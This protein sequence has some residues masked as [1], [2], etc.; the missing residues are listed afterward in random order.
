MTT[1]LAKSP[2]SPGAVVTLAQIA[3]RQRAGSRPED[4]GSLPLSGIVVPALREAIV[5]G[6]LLPGARLSEVQIG[7]EFGVSRTPVRE[8]FA[9]L[10]REGLVTVVP[11]VGAFVRTVT[12]DDV[13]EIYAVRAALEAAAVQLAAKRLTPIGRAELDA[14]VAA[15]G[16]RL[17]HNDHDGFVAALD[18]FYAAMMALTGNATLRR[19]HESL[20]GPVRR[21]RRIAMARPGRM[22]EAYAQTLVIRDAV[23][24]GDPRCADHMRV[25]LEKACEAAKQVLRAAASAPARGE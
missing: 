24:A 7:T 10:E 4:D 18:G 16:D 19:T 9:Q 13:D 20:L 6:H 14:V 5:D 1:Q 25:Q 12:I 8:A 15:M 21:L 17:E 2:R 23:V 3:R 22:A 11:R